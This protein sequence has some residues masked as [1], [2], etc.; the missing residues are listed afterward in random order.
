MMRMASQ[1]RASPASLTGVAI[2][3]SAAAAKRRDAQ[4]GVRHRRRT[5]ICNPTSSGYAAVEP[6][7]APSAWVG[8]VP[9]IVRMIR[10]SQ[11]PQGRTGV[12]RFGFD[13]T[14]CG[15]NSAFRNSPRDVDGQERSMSSCL[16]GLFL[17]AYGCL[18][19]PWSLLVMLATRP[20]ERRFGLGLPSGYNS[21]KKRF[22]LDLCHQPSHAT[23][24]T[25]R[26]PG[27]IS[28]TN[29][30][31]LQFHSSRDGLDLC[32][33]P[34]YATISPKQR[35]GLDLCSQPSH[36]TIHTRRDSGLISATIHK[37]EIRV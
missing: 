11:R 20:R 33:Q 17:I 31:M 9:D 19:E 32:S 13:Q 10:T 34:S 3:M 16:F 15:F 5:I 30:P 2:A 23:I 8:S 12:Q 27:L 36:A 21:Y 35:P 37:E 29:H 26:D 28:A 1:H 24:H 18:I 7:P 25:R 6:P 14:L 22:G 4:V